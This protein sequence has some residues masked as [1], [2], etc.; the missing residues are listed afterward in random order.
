MQHGRNNYDLT[1]LMEANHGAGFVAALY[2]Y[3]TSLFIEYTN[4]NP[5]LSPL[6]IASRGL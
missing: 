2:L 6:M 4:M 5:F 3:I 1:L